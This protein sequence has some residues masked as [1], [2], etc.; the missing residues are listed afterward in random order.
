MAKQSNA[1]R[2]ARIL[3]VVGRLTGKNRAWAAGSLVKEV[4]QLSGF[5][6]ADVR[7][8]LYVLEERRLIARSTVGGREV[9]VYTADET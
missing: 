7:E 9:V 6:E 2:N 4:A 1:V 5:S 8:G 3:T